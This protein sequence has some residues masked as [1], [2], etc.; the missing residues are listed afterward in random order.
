MMTDC[1][2][3]DQTEKYHYDSPCNCLSAI[4]LKLPGVASLQA[5]P[6]LFCIFTN[7]FPSDRAPRA[8]SHTKSFLSATCHMGKQ[9]Q[10]AWDNVLYTLTQT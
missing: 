4:L 3:N 2:M 5:N 9:D 6:F 8:R 7:H 10:V 1:Y